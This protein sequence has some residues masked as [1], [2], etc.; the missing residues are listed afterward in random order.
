MEKRFVTV[1]GAQLQVSL[2]G[3]GEPVVFIQTAL[4]AD[5][6]RPLATAPALEDYRKV[7]Y[8]RRGYEPS[9]PIEEPGSIARD[10]ADCAAL[11]NEVEI[12]R[13]HVVGLSY[14]GAVA[15]QLAVDAPDITHSLTLIEPPPVHTRTA[16]EFRA[17]NDR[18]IQTRRQ[19]GPAA[20]L[21]EFMTLVVGSN[22]HQ[23][24]E[25]WLPGSSAQMRRDAPTFF[26]ADLPALLDWDFDRGDVSRIA[27]PVLYVGGTD[28]GPWF[29][30]VRELILS[31][32]PDADNVAIEGADHS[33]AL[34]HAPQIADALIAFLG[35]HPMRR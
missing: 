35:R 11:L 31:W 26:D 33:L 10:A 28:S 14:S 9:S 16:P 25:R 15:L 12:Q 17:T 24:A 6:L 18:L 34:T 5:E 29:A 1:P 27:S 13:A 2:W 32:F 21:E 22:W 3:S 30:E 7:L 20:A 19:Q 8:Y 23:V 4:T